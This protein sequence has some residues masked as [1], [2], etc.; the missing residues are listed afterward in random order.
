ML[1]KIW[2]IGKSILFLTILC[3]TLYGVTILVL[4]EIPDFY[5]E[6]E[7]DVVF[8]GTS[9]TYCTFDPMIFDEY[10]LKTYN[11]G[12]QQQTMNYTYYYIKDAFDVSDIDVVVLEIFGMFY[13]EG[14]ERFINETIRESS[15]GDFRY[16]PIKLEVIRECVPEE[17]QF[18]YLFPLD[19]YHSNW[20]KWDFTSFDAF[21]DTVIS[22]YYFEG[23]DRGY[24]RWSSYEWTD[25]PDWGT[26]HS[27]YHEDVYE[28]NMKY[29]EMIREL[30]EANNAELLLVRGP[31]PCYEMVI[32]KTNTIMDWAIDNHVEMVNFMNLTGEIGMDFGMD[33]LDGGVHLNES[34]AAK[35]SRYLA[36]Y[37]M[38]NYF[39]W[40]LQ[41]N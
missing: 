3:V 16:S 39:G 12:R 10:A 23:E 24:K 26:L 27:G 25:Y 35:V 22:P 37:L 17:K 38:D 15:L 19:K 4:P 31:F 8:F 11:R 18:P 41:S 21:Q 14:D 13:D 6:D 36:E 20:E 34:G 29:L 28:E 40:D 7:W 2:K 5:K 1:Q 30:C 32:G 33:S 9:Q